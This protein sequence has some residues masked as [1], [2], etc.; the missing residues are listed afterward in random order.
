MKDPHSMLHG[1]F[2]A[3]L[4]GGRGFPHQSSGMFRPSEGSATKQTKFGAFQVG[5]CRRKI[6]CRLAGIEAEGVENL[7]HQIQRM[8]VGKE[9]ENSIIETAKR[10]GIY[11]ANNVPF[12]VTM[13]GVPIAGEMD[14]IFRTEPCGV[15]RYL[16]EIKSIYG[17]PAQKAIFGKFINHGRGL[18][19]VPRDSYI[20]QTA[21]YLNHFSRLPK[22]H[23]SYLPFGVIFVCDRGDGHFGVFDIWLQE[24]IRILGEGESVTVHK[25]FY[26]SNQMGV[27]VTEVPYT[28]EDILYS[29]KV[30]QNALE[31]GEMPEKDYIQEYNRDEVELRHEAGMISASQ[32][33]KW[34][35]S[36]G[37][38]G[39]GK[40]KLG[41]WGCFPLYCKWAEICWGDK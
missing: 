29:F 41:D 22:D 40:E 39:K 11:V 9:V 25:I 14:A 4:M 34:M 32:Y 23:P 5:A 33:K 7:P 6:Y 16:A 19:G 10:S 1:V 27:P 8:N 37:P 28:V 3:S 35:G 15:D 30:V 2:E 24:E 12:R 17:Y 20:M 13:D 26:R 21:L 38:R 36:H 18:P 31:T